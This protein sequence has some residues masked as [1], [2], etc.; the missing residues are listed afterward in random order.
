M[1]P[2]KVSSLYVITFYLLLTKTTFSN[3]ISFDT[4]RLVLNGKEY[5]LEIAR[6]TQQRLHGLMYREQLDKRQGMLFLYPRSGSHR[7]WMKNT[8]IPL[9]VIWIDDT[10]TII[11][12][13]K[14]PPCTADPCPSYGVAKPSKYILELSAENHGLHPGLSLQGFDFTD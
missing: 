5:E 3:D 13:K 11:G 10:G 2:V 1:M 7:I 4:E 9:T 8:L 12:I 6:S 14:L